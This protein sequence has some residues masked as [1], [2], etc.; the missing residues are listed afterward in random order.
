MRT[1]MEQ[2]QVTYPCIAVHIDAMPLSVIQ[3]SLWYSQHQVLCGASG[4]QVDG[5]FSLTSD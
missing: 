4:A 1:S 3:P 2:G 5:E